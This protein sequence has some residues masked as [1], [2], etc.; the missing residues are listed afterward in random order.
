MEFYR[1]T[2]VYRAGV[3]MRGEPTNPLAEPGTERWWSE[4]P[5]ANLS[6]AHRNRV[7]GRATSGMEHHREVIGLASAAVYL[8]TKDGIFVTRLQS[9]K[10]VRWRLTWLPAGFH[11]LRLEGTGMVRRESGSS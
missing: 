11:L 10:P 2:C 1:G 3:G 4:I 8:W 9:T 7:G 5:R 6:T